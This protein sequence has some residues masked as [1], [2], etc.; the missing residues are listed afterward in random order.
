MSDG[1]AQRMVRRVRAAGKLLE[2]FIIHN[3]QA[4]EGLER[5]LPDLEL[6]LAN[7]PDL[8]RA[9][10]EVYNYVEKQG[11]VMSQAVESLRAAREE[12]A[13]ADRTASD[14]Q[15]DLASIETYLSAMEVYLQAEVPTIKRVLELHDLPAWEQALEQLDKGRWLLM[16]EVWRRVASKRRAVATSPKK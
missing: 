5:A 8:L 13:R 3:R 1:I 11:E 4:R 7:N 9:I 10:R 14:A 12:A 16:D 15:L 2:S 6:E